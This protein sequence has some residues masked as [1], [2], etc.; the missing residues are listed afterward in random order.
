M[1]ALAL[2]FVQELQDCYVGVKS[3]NGRITKRLVK[4]C[5]QDLLHCPVFRDI[6]VEELLEEA[7]GNNNIS[8]II[9]YADD[10]AKPPAGMV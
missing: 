3:P 6:I 9:T 10:K 7:E 8:L 5:L 2:H 1:A 4:G